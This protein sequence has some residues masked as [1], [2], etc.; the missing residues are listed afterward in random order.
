MLTRQFPFLESARIEP[1]LARR[2]RTLAD[3]C[4]RLELGHPVSPIVLAKAPLLEDWVPT[5]TALGV[6][7]VG[8]VSPG[9]PFRAIAKSP[10]PPSGPQT[11][12]A[13]GPAPCP[14]IIG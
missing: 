13:L 5:V 8:Q 12:T 3:D 6:H 9:I 2:L 10:P 14:A 11:L 1:D 7:L 4:E